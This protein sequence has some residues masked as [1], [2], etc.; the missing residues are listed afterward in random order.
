[1]K[2]AVLYDSK[3]ENTTKMA[4]YIA[5][6]AMEIPFVEA[7]AFSVHA[8]DEEFIKESKAVIIGTPTYAAI[9]SAD[10]K[11]WLEQKTGS[12]QLAGKLGG[13]FATANYV[14]GGGELAVQ[15]IIT[16][17]MCC[18]MMIY[19]GGAAKG[20]PVIHLGPVAISPNLD[21]YAETFRTYGKRMAEQMTATFK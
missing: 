4:E 1:M 11:V 15:C 18:G 7:K 12:L 17:L 6:G 3:T 19:S 20:L 2:L 13:A 10:L 5:E 16:H 8:A 14:H 9:L 21:E